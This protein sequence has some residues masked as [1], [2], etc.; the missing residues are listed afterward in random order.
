MRMGDT[1]AMSETEIRPASRRL[2]PRE[3]H[4][5]AV[6]SGGL[7]YSLTSLV[8]LAIPLTIG[9]LTSPLAPMIAVTGIMVVYGIVFV[10]ACGIGFY[11]LR[12]RLAWYVAGFVLLAVLV[13]FM[14]SAVLYLVVFQTMV[15]VLLLPW[16][17]AVPMLAIISITAFVASILSQEYIASALA[18]VAFGMSWA[19]G[20]GIQKEIL[21]ARLAAAEERNAVLAVAVERERIGRDLHD[22]LGHSLTTMTVSAQLAKRLIAS[23][24][25]RAR[26]QIELIE[27]TSRHALADVRA[28]T[29]GMQHVRAAG[30]IASARSVLDAAGIEV[31]A[32]SAL[33]DLE[34]GRSELFGYA[35]REGITNVVRHSS[36]SRARIV[37]EETSVEITDDGVGIRPGDRRSGLDGLRRRMEEAGGRLEV[38][39]TSP[40]T[41]LRASFGEDSREASGLST[42]EVL[43]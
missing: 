38:E 40:G 30:E 29:S 36:A 6:A 15:T 1:G 25:D 34:D 31:E 17:W 22:I 4:R 41:R 12:V 43:R 8:F 37:V 28:T 5:A 16:R 2:T 27:R 3:V 13:A 18:F 24:P 11:P 33:P 32:P 21:D 39:P 7:P 14:G 19:V 20:T 9:Y 26:E 42:S 23:D 10:Y 35:I